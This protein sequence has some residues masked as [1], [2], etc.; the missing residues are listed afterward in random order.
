M[1]V[2]RNSISRAVKGISGTAAAEGRRNEIKQ[3]AQ[4]QA[5]QRAHEG[6]QSLR[7]GRAGVAA[8]PRTYPYSQSVGSQAD[9]AK[10]CSD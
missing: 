2:A 8:E 4:H 1:D 6:D 7:T 3:S 10:D 5:G 9:Q